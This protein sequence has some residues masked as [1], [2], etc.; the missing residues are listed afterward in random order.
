MKKMLDKLE[1]WFVVYTL[2]L[3]TII[4]FLQ[5][6]MRYVFMNSLSWSEELA[7]YMFLWLSWIG[8]SYAVKEHAHLRVEVVANIF[9]GKN[10]I[11]YEILVYVGWSIFTIFLAYQGFRAMFFLIESGQSSPALYMPM[12][13][14]YASVPVGCTLMAY[15]L[16][17][18]MR[19]LFA[20][21]RDY[22]KTPKTEV[23]A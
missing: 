11:L 16:I 23:T 5:V 15:R 12:F 7:R 6:I 17:C 21:L 2:A 4:I 9:K 22:G 8:A 14:P 3:M 13:I 18:E 10:R 19:K 20:E 1:E